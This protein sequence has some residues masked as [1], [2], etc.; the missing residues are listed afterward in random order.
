MINVEH[1]NTM[2][3]TLLATFQMRDPLCFVLRF[4][5]R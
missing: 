2:K 3:A 5:R 4:E 1:R